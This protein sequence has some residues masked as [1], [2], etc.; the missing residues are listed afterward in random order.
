MPGCLKDA[1]RVARGKFKKLVD[2]ERVSTTEGN[3]FCARTVYRV[4]SVVYKVNGHTSDNAAEYYLL[5]DMSGY[6]W[7]PPVDLYEVEGYGPILCMP[8]YPDLREHF[9]VSTKLLDEICNVLDDW[10]FAH[11]MMVPNPDM[12]PGNYRIIGPEQVMVIDAVGT[13]PH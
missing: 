6:E 9:T 2:A 11:G 13:F 4:G 10:M 7:A 8:Y 1:R 5:R 3:D 12:H